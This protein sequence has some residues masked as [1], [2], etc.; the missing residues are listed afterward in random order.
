MSGS[1]NLS[2]SVLMEGLVEYSF[3]S[4]PFILLASCRSASA[5]IE[6]ALALTAMKIGNI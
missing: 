1:N 2:G 4:L 6:A 5:L 3:Q